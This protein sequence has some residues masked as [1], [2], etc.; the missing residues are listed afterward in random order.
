MKT[1]VIQP[2][3]VA[4]DESLDILEQTVRN[5]Y[6]YGFVTDIESDAAPKGLDESTIR[7]ISAKK[8]S[9]NGCWNGA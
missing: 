8:R 1:D 7:F 9:R 3:N 5:E 4:V 2:E 6:K